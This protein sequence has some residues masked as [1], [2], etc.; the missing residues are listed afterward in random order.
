MSS[1]SSVD[2]SR[3]TETEHSEELDGDFVVG[4]LVVVV[5]VVVDVKSEVWLLQLNNN[6]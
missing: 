6:K 3:G 5:V 4:E 1:I 2:I